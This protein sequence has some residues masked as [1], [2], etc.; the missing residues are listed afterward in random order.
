MSKLKIGDKLQVHCYKHNG[1][2]YRVCDE[3]TVVDVQ[4]DFL[5]CGNY[6]TRITE[7][8]N[9]E[10]VNFY[11]YKTNEPAILFFF[12][13]KWYNVIGQLKDSGV[14]Y[15]CNIASPYIIDDGLIKYI[16]YDLDLRVFPNGSFKV[17]DRG[18]YK[19]H[20][21]VMEYS[22]DL[23]KILRSELTKLIE[24]ARTHE[25]EFS[26]ENILDYYEKYKKILKKS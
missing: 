6:K 25:K 23:D 1:T 19:Y 8:D 12:K 15:Y 2:L 9:I 3:A 13:D 14:Y 18:E 26:S 10:K 7:K 24:K 21:R 16:D 22:K 17:L 5:V 20:K 4:P 11:S